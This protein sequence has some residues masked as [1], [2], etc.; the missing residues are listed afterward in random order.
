MGKAEQIHRVAFA[1]RWADI[2]EC[3]ELA[4]DLDRHRGIKRPVRSSVIQQRSRAPM[5]TLA[6]QHAAPRR[7]DLLG[8]A[9]EVVPGDARDDRAAAHVGSN[10]RDE[11]HAAKYLHSTS[12]RLRWA[13][14]VA[15]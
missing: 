3:D 5:D 1:L 15:R 7:A 12:D 4:H 8:R 13:P 10:V 2:G 6:C 9:P 11:R 14:R